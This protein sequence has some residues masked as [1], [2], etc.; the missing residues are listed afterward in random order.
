MTTSLGTLRDNIRLNPV[1]SVEKRIQ[2]LLSLRESIQKHESEI[3]TSLK[4]DL[5]KSISES[6]IEL[7]GVLSEIELMVKELPSWAQ[8][9]K[10]ATPLVLQPGKSSIQFSPFGLVL[11][12]APWNYPFQ[13][14]FKP[15]IG[16]IAAGN[17]V[18]LKPSEI[19]STVSGLIAKIV[20]SALPATEVVVIEGDAQKTQ[21]LLK[22]R[23]DFIFFTGSTQVGRV[24]MKA[25]AEHLTPVVLEL[26][27]KSPCLVDETADLKQTAKR[28]VWG[29]FSNAGQTCV[30]P[31]YVL[32]HQ[33]IKDQLIKECQEVLVQFY[34][35]DPKAS[36]DF[37]R[38]VSTKH[39]DRL[40]NL[41]NGSKILFG[42]QYDQAERYLAPTLVDDV[43]W[44]DK[45]MSE[46]IFGPILPFITYD[47]LDDALDKIRS[48]PKPLALYLFSAN[49][50][51]QDKV[52]TQVSFGGGCV[53]DTIVHLGNH[54]LPFGG[55][56]E[57]G[58]GFY[59]GKHSFETFSHK[60]SIFKQTTL[61]DI[62]VRYPPYGNKEKLIKFLLG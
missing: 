8:V 2:H 9:E 46:E 26:G 12:L 45:L 58:M 37:G 41:L 43:N 4:K 31:D 21:E 30:A 15:L 22:E 36:P 39:L 44:N 47:D 23:F 6:W 33:S 53:N 24:V 49:S 50:H 32:A 18:V 40:V 13:L 7:G 54:H 14:A 38:I 52:T 5:G 60:K 10:V 34:G 51:H 62:P 16:A 19:S 25:A 61:V 55:V 17:R 56:G 11:I 27:G 28:I 29:K 20:Q 1:P 42:G 57:S 59:H 35:K 48:L 3:L